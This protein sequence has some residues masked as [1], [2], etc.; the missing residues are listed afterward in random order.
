MDRLFWTGVRERGRDGGDVRTR[1][2]V[3]SGRRVR[4]LRHCA[5][6]C[7]RCRSARCG[8]PGCDARSALHHRPARG[9]LVHICGVRPV[10]GFPSCAAARSAAGSSCCAP[11]PPPS[12][13]LPKHG[14][15][16]SCA[17]GHAGW[18]AEGTGGD[19]HFLLKNALRSPNRSEARTDHLIYRPGP[20]RPR[21]MQ[22]SLMRLNPLNSVYYLD[23]DTS[24]KSQ[25][26]AP[27]E[28]TI[29]LLIRASLKLNQVLYP[30]PSNLRMW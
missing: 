6:L 15:L 25:T 7:V 1:V 2:S 28:F 4:E 22:E 12:C 23:L 30:Y 21:L 29:A 18:G 16:A 5:H 17:G 3:A 13:A 19:S 26:A 24:S 10:V 11:L 9:G 27:T 8:W 14:G 20:S